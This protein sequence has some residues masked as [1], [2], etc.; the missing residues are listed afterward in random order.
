MKKSQWGQALLFLLFFG[1]LFLANLI[2][3]DRVFSPVENRTLASAPALT[4]ESVF[5]G[6][7]MSEFESYVTDQFVLRDDWTALKAYVERAAGKRENNDVYI[8]GDTL[9]ERFELADERQLAANL[10]AVD[11]FTA[12]TD[13][14]VYLM[15]IPTA[16]GVWRDRLPEGAPSCDQEAILVG[17]PE[18]TR[19]EVVNAWGVLSVHADEAIYYRTDHHWTSLGACYGA[20]AL[21]RAMGKEP[22]SPDRWT[23]ETV[24]DDFCGTLWS[25]S[26]ARYIPPDTIKIYVPEDGIQVNSLE[27]GQ[28]REGPLYA[29]EKLRTKDQYAVFLG[30]NQP[31]AV[32]RT[33]REG[34]KLLLI[35]DSYADSEVPFLLDA[36]SEIHLIDLRYWRQD[37]AAYVRENGIDRVAVSYSL[38]NFAEDTNLYF[39]GRAGI[40]AGG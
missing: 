28:W 21:L 16:A 30:G 35:R 22:A 5:S 15:L 39:L 40:G 6:R 25:R 12:R 9:I 23:P 37:V 18:R 1:G 4:A 10:L 7:F 14:P 38:K 26:G 19:A 36:F 31:L 8:A 11:R 20:A 17:L 13:A 24:S 34:E 29:R 33:G 2:S 3:P 27:G 32:I